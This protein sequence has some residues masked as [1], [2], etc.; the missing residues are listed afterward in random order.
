[1]HEKQSVSEQTKRLSKKF[2]ALAL[3][4]EKGTPLAWY[5]F[6][7]EESATGIVMA[8]TAS[9]AVAMD[10]AN[11]ISL[12][13]IVNAASDIAIFKYDPNHAWPQG[14]FIVCIDA[15]AINENILNSFMPP[16]GIAPRP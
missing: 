5:A 8:T 6:P 4:D 10:T 11:I 1:M 16:K 9:E 7:H 13:G 12:Y 14:Y 15:P 3:K 2:D